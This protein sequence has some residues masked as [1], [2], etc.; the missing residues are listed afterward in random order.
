VKMADASG[1]VELDDKVV[2]QLIEKQGCHNT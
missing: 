2:L 1:I